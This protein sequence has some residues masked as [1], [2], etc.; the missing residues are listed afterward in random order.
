MHTISTNALSSAI[1]Y[2][3]QISQIQVSVSIDINLSTGKRWIV[4]KG[5]VPIRQYAIL[6]FVSFCRCRNG[7]HEQFL[8]SRRFYTGEAISESGLPRNRNGNY[9]KRAPSHASD[10]A[11]TRASLL[12]I[13]P[14]NATLA[15]SRELCQ[16]A[17]IS[18]SLRRARLEESSQISRL[19][20]S[21]QSLAT[22]FRRI[23]A[24]RVHTGCYED[25]VL[26]L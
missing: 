24:T 13:R 25:R 3:I 26:F 10:R 8:G 4:H 12:L 2:Y 19:V 9:D 14:L 5:N 20:A 18:V 15:L 16:P 23:L 7:G 11:H 17:A 22:W 21:E 1:K 6:I